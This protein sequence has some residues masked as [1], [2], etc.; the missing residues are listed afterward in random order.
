MLSGYARNEWGAALVV[1]FMLTAA[2][3]VVGWWWLAL[4]LVLLTAAVVLF[5]RDPQRRPP[6]QRGVFV[7]PADGRVSSVHTVDH[8]EPLGGPALCVRIFLSVFDVHVNRSPCH[9]VVSSITHSDG[10]H[11]SALN[12]QSAEVNQ[13]T[14]MVLVHPIKRH[15]I[16]AVRQVAGQFAR[17]IVNAAEVDATLQRGQRFG[18]IK[19]GSTTELY[20]PATL[21]PKPAVT[22]GQRVI[23]GVTVV[24]T[25]HTTRDEWEGAAQRGADAAPPPAEDAGDTTPE[26]ADAPPQPAPEDPAATAS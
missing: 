20:V 16:A 10:Q 22:Q 17:T 24:V 23:G 3:A 1:G 12:P 2:A 18:I 25:V 8:F 15:P 19:L 21:D 7:A 13:S 6:A 5:F 14:M 4:P 9:G 11:L 26:H